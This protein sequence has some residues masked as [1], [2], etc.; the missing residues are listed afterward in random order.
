MKSQIING[1][2]YT[3]ETYRN[4]AGQIE[5]YYCSY[6]GHDTDF[7]KHGEGAANEETAIVIYRQRLNTGHEA[8]IAFFKNH[9]ELNP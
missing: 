4:D 3:A 2:T 5:G 7:I 1:E 6:N 8:E 9:P